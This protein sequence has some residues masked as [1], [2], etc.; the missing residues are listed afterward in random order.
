MSLAIQAVKDGFLT[1][2]PSGVQV[3]LQDL[4]LFQVYD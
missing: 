3:T 2:I 4:N 1:R